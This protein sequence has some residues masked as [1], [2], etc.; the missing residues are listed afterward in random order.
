MSTFLRSFQYIGLI[1]FHDQAENS[2]REFSAGN[3][4]RGFPERLLR[5]LRSL[6]INQ[7]KQIIQ[8]YSNKKQISLKKQVEFAFDRLQ[9]ALEDG[10]QK[11]ID[12]QQAL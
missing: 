8:D 11:Q 2:L 5:S 4:L 9:T 7:H 3:P 12:K 10:N 1:F 6:A